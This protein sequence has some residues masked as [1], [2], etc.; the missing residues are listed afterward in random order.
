MRYN[1]IDLLNTEGGRRKI[2]QMKATKHNKDFT[3]LAQMLSSF[4][5]GLSDIDKK[6]I[7]KANAM[8]RDEMKSQLAVLLKRVFRNAGLSYEVE[9]ANLK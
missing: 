8:Y 2:Q 9:K 1:D 4:D 7:S 3:D 6:M 5:V